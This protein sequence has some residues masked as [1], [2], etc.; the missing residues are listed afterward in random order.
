[1]HDAFAYV[2]QIAVNN[3]NN[4]INNDNN[5]A[6][7]PWDLAEVLAKPIYWRKP[8]PSLRFRW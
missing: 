2:Q 3:D 6:S 7:P 8:F 4:N 1:M 5:S